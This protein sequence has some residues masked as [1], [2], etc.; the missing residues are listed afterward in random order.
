MCVRMFAV[1][2]C[3]ESSLVCQLKHSLV[4]VRQSLATLPYGPARL[5]G[6]LSGDH[7]T[8]SALNLVDP[9][10]LFIWLSVV[11]STHQVCRVPLKCS[12]GSSCLSQFLSYLILLLW[13]LGVH[14][15]CR[16]HQAIYVHCTPGATHTVLVIK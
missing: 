11:Q 10:P 16:V 15:R 4:S 8:L 9:A 1:A 14:V 2:E 7:N 13:L 5:V 12:S 3:L 6:S